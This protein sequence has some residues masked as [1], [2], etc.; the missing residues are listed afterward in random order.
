MDEHLKNLLEATWDAREKW[1][2]LGVELG[3]R[4]GALEVRCN[5]RN[6]IR[7]SK[8]LAV[9]L[10]VTFEFQ[11][12]RFDFKNRPSRC[13]IAALEHW[14]TQTSVPNVAGLIKVLQSPTI[15][16]G[17][18]AKNVEDMLNLSGLYIAL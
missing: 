8:S 2:V 9:Y 6:F 17:D 18:I 16:C 1:Q 13:Y 12:I 15:D 14:L 7:N 10:M 11:A 4:P 3:M 5:T